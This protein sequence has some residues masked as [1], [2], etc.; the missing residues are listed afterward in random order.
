MAARHRGSCKEEKLPQPTPFDIHC[1]DSAQRD[2]I[3]AV[4]SAVA[5]LL[6]QS[7]C[8]PHPLYDSARFRALGD[9]ECLA[10]NHLVG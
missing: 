10:M 4:K 6:K 9:N 7:N 2:Q 8:N 1:P 3:E 5:A